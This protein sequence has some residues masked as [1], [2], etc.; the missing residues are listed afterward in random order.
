MDASMQ[1]RVGTVMLGSAF[2]LTIVGN[3]PAAAQD[4]IP[5][6]PQIE[7]AY[8]Q[9]TDA[10]FAPIYERLK[11][12]KVLETLQRFLSPLQL[13]RK[14]T[15]K[16]DQC[17][18]TMARHTH[19][20]AATICYEYIDQVN[21]LAPKNTVA[22]VQGPVTNESAIVGPVV[23]AILHEVALAAFDVLDLPVWGRQDDAA[24]R[25]AAFIMVQFGPDVA[26]NTVVGT[27]WFLA[28]NA[29]ASPDFA[30]V[31]GVV[32]QRYYTTLCIAYGAEQS[33]A[34]TASS[35]AS[36]SKFVANQSSGS[37][38]ADRGCAQEYALVKQGFDDEIKPHVNQK[39]MK[40]VQET[41]WVASQTDG[42]PAAALRGDRITALEPA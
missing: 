7:I 30:E 39:L 25:V 9:P 12:R 15:V 19:E 2:V 16:L 33:A 26:C 35:R 11:E 36:F 29:A 8:V 32:A 1:H 34:F 28:G 6:N 13:D 42:K 23:Q 41:D 3:P 31:R 14:L 5:P 10:K 38:P 18:A 40:A 24:D 20:G 27:A 22:L 17:G 4:A 21:L 37:L